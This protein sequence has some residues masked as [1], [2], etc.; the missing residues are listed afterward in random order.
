MERAEFE[1]L[2]T[3]ALEK[4]P[5]EFRAKLSNVAIVVE[6]E[7]TQEQLSAARIHPKTTLLGLYEGVPQTKRS[8]FSFGELPDK[9][10]IFKQPIESVAPDPDHIREIVHDTV[11]HEVGHH[12][13][14]SEERIRRWETLRRG[15]V[16]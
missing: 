9:I 5:E 6:D 3:E 10:T 12:F 1:R 7:P 2:V 8:I 11:L 15:G 16:Q 13:G 4:L 14:M